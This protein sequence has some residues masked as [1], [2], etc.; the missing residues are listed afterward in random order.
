MNA[1]EGCRERDS[2][3]QALAALQFSRTRFVPRIAVSPSLAN[4]RGKFR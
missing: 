3:W 4:R 1:G 2:G